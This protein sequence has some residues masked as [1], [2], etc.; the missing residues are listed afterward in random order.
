MHLKNK[1]QKL[2]TVYFVSLGCPKNRVDTDIMAATLIEKKL[3]LVFDPD[4]AD[5][6]VVNT[7]S[8]I[9]DAKE[10]SVDTLLEMAQQ[11]KTG[12]CQLLIAAGCLPQRNGDELKEAMPEID[13][14][15]GTGTPDKIADVIEGKNVALG[16]HRGAH[17]LQSTATPRLVTPGQA[18]VYIKIADGC[19]RKCAFCAIPGIRGK[20]ESRPIDNI[21]A[22]AKMLAKSGAKE[23]VLVAQD[24]AAYGKDLKDGTDLK[25][26]L[27]ALNDLKGI[28]WIRVMYLYPDSVD[29]SLLK[30]MVDLKKVVPYLDIPIQHASASMLKAMRRGHG[31][32]QLKTCIESAKRI[33]P[34]AFL[35]T[36]ILV[37]FPG[38][39]DTDVAELIDFI[40][41]AKFHHLGAFRYSDEEGTPAFG[42][43]PQVTK[44]DS[45]NRYRKVMG[46]QRKIVAQN[47]KALMGEIIEV[48]IENIADEAGFVLEG[49]HAG[50]A[51]EIDGVTYVVNAEA[52]IGDILTCKIIDSK[53]YDLVAE[54]V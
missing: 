48:L 1:N 25:S 17:F 31:K 9:G 44:K 50:Q 41:F 35:R 54:P 37:G 13:A 40:K 46:I 53:A 43:M 49:R 22:E 2:Q 14:M 10:E 7:C 42:K 5:V 39:T 30:A 4:D 52:K 29:N 11:K 23:L 33:M 12:R 28:Q 16:L 45:Y 34:N 6:I 8:F 47:N 18:S 38:E 3:K 15:L 24:T 26:L 36:T 19:S 20:G 32:K 21:V 51:P 27:A